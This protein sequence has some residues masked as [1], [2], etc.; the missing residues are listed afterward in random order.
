[1][2]YA[3]E[4]QLVAVANACRHFRNVSSDDEF[5]ISCEDCKNWSGE[6]C[7]ADVFDTVLTSLDQT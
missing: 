3:S 7:T 5:E 2:N 4:D 1:M 6:Y